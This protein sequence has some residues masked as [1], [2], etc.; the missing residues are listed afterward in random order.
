LVGVDRDD[1]PGGVEP[2]VPSVPQL[3]RNCKVHG[4]WTFVRFELELTFDGEDWTLVL[5]NDPL[6]E[7]AGTGRFE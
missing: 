1:G 4:L 6:R 2:R 3:E 7:V 5:E